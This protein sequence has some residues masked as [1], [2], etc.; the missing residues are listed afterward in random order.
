MPLLRPPVPA[1]RPF[2]A[3]LWASG[4]P[5]D[6]AGASPWREHALPSGAM[7]LVVRLTDRVLRIADPFQHGSAQAVVPSLVGGMRSR[8]YVRELAG[9]SCS[10]GAVLRPGAA[11]CLF[12][13]GADALAERHTSLEDLWGL[14]ARELRERLLSQRRPEDRLAVFEAELAARLPRVHGLHP[15]VAQALAQFP[16]GASV[17][18]V[19]R[20][21]G[22]SHRRFIEL[23]RRS[24]GLAPK[25]FLRVLRFQRAL[26]ALRAGQPLA[27]VAVDLGYSDQSHFSREFLAFSGV[28]PLAYRLQH[29]T[30]MNH[31]PMKAG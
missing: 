13:V 24:V 20:Q 12:G 2:V 27:A 16:A 23:F 26:P 28:T 15:A 6:A 18:E 9:P 29:G 1:L 4:D 21:G 31:L 17:A 7:H 10:V 5:V 3:Q 19:V 25:T 8:Y 11:Q 14:A 22:V 30:E